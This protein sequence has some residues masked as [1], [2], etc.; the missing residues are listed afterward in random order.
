MSH[1]GMVVSPPS[2]SGL[3]HLSFKEASEDSTS[4]RSRKLSCSITNSPTQ[5]WNTM[6]HQLP[7]DKSSL[8]SIEKAIINSEVVMTPNN[9]GEV[10]R[11]SI[12]Q[13]TSE[14]WFIFNLHY[15]LVT[16]QSSLRFNQASDS[17]FLKFRK[18][19]KNKITLEERMR[20]GSRKKW[21]EDHESRKEEERL[22]RVEEGT[23]REEKREIERREKYLLKE[24]LKAERMRQKEELR[25]EK[26]TGRRKTALEMAYARKIAR[27]SM[28]L[29]EDEQLEMMELAASS[30]GL[31]SIIILDLDTLQ[32]IESFRG[33]LCIFPP[34][35][36]KLRK[37][38][39]FQPWINSEENV[40]NLLM[41]MELVCWIN[42]YVD[43]LIFFSTYCTNCL[44]LI[45]LMA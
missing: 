9:D 30:K 25:K 43:A 14:I 7:Y 28:E 41:C 4:L 26:E 23:K 2:S 12:P 17:I 21:R 35:N 22:M 37:P 36:V 19:S 18:S 39:A 45:W 6:D 42:S 3:G 1:S 40:G 11:L 16:L 24:N 15:C 5:R 29:I 44:Y 34:E 31:S 13:L 38:F 32:N 33:S 27:E 20:S 10:I 8:K